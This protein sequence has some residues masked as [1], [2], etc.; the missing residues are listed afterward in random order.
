MKKVIEFIKESIGE[1]K[2]VTWPSKDDVVGQ[3]IVVVVSLVIVSVVLALMD[4]FSLQAIS[5]IIT[6]GM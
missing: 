1:L 5:K 4:F 6:L 2:R 3:T